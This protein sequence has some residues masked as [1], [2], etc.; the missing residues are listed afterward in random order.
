MG[1]LSS[2]LIRIEFGI[3]VAGAPVNA[4]PAIYR[5]TVPPPG[6]P[7]GGGTPVEDENGLHLCSNA[8]F[9]SPKVWNAVWND[10]ADFQLLSDKLEYGK[11]YY[12][13]KDGAKICTERCQMSVIGIASDTFGFGVGSG[14]HQS[15][16]PIAIA[17]W[18]LAYVDKEYECGTPLTNDEN[19]NL[20][21]M[22]RA[23]KL[24][25][26]ERIVAIYKRKEMD[27]NWGPANQQIVV[28]GRHW[29]KVKG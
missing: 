19:G 6:L 4:I 1:K 15:Q 13:T 5:G 11:C 16:V 3:S 12:D 17:G 10:V 8:E 22:T 7:N 20:T 29:V 2:K 14:A 18:V 25:Y 26:P 28:N 9:V 24:E 21:A 23:E 27:A